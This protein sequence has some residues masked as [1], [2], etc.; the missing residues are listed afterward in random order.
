MGFWSFLSVYISLIAC[1]YFISCNSAKKKASASINDTNK[2]NINNIISQEKALEDLE[3]L[4]DIINTR[5]PATMPLFNLPNGDLIDSVKEKITDD[6]SRGNFYFLIQSILASFKDAHTTANAYLSLRD[7]K[8]TKINYL[9]LSDGLYI[10]EDIEGLVKGDKILSING[11]NTD[12]ILYELSLIVSNENINWVKSRSNEL[13]NMEPYL[14]YLNLMNEN[15]EMNFVIIRDGQEQNQSIGLKDLIGKIP[16]EYNS[17]YYFKLM[18]DANLGF[19]QINACINN[20]EY[21]TYLQNCFIAI[22]EN[23]IKNIVI[24]LRK[25]GDG[26]PSVIGRFL[27]YLAVDKYRSFLRINKTPEE[28]ANQSKYTSKEDYFASMPYPNCSINHNIDN[29]L[30]FDGK[31]YI[32][33]SKDTFGSGNWFGAIFQDNHLATV[34]GEPSG[35]APTGYGDKLDFVLPNSNIYFTMSQRIWVRPDPRREA[36][37]LQPDI[38]VETRMEDILNEID[39][40]LEKVKELIKIDY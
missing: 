16:F 15:N 18:E 19:F 12:Q 6:I 4:R 33:I 38:V 7:F 20:Y 31:I 28:E 14:R 10:G 29:E 21:K 40:Q 2:T 8:T 32:L 23:N 13:L 26:D 17:D 34:V 35:N 1:M 30:I 25:S 3:Y 27:K 22:K 39:P 9:W 11:K 36:A 37:L 5:H 24:D